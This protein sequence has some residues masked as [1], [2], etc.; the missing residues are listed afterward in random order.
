[1]SV[2]N[3]ILSGSIT[4]GTTVTSVGLD[5]LTGSF[6]AF[7]QGVSIRDINDL[8]NFVSFKIRPNSSFRMT[9]KGRDTP[10]NSF[11]DSLALSSVSGI[12]PASS[13]TAL[14][15]GSMAMISLGG[16]GRL[17]KRL[18]HVAERR[19]LGQSE[20]YE[21]DHFL[22][23]HKPTGEY[24]IG[25]H[26]IS[27]EVPNKIVD[28]SNLSSFDGVIEPLEIRRIADRTSIEAPYVAYSI[29]GSL[30]GEE[31]KFK[32]VGI[33]TDEVDLEEI[34]NPQT[35]WFLDAV[36]HMGTVD[37]PGVQ[38]VNTAKIPAF[39]DTTDQEA[40]VQAL[41]DTE[42]KGILAQANYTDDDAKEHEITARRGFVFH[43]SS[44]GYDSIA[45]GGLK[46]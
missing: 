20:Y 33:I 42:I 31:D 9:F 6:D 13:T 5:S 23:I 17:G 38:N 40:T 28:L 4:K 46:K 19:D 2:S 26:P 12:Q 37:L 18:T 3:R 14:N 29:K 8:Y 44:T 11:D 7:R 43:Y 32:H 22:D 30:G 45:F 15:T 25:T 27:V 41:E 34:I 35:V 24:L 36:E 10:D 1:M 16:A 39:K 21:N